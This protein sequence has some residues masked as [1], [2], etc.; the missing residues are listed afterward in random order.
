MTGL[1]LVKT[2]VFCIQKAPRGKAH[3]ESRNSTGILNL[4]TG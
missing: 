1:I 4:G 3:E 2:T